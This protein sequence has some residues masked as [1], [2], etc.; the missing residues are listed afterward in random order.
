MGKENESLKPPSTSIKD[1]ST[2]LCLCALLCVSYGFS[3][4]GLQRIE[5]SRTAGDRF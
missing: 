5:A 2:V 3:Q 4:Y 1:N